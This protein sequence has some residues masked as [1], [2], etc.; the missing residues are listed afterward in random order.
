MN[1]KL[2]Q[3]NFTEII[4]KINQ[5]NIINLFYPPVCRYLWKN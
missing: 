5:D 1:K 4:S 2:K 3:V